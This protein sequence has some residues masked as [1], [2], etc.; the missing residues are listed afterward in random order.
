[1]YSKHPNHTYGRNRNNSANNW[2]YMYNVHEPGSYFFS[3]HFQSL[4]TPF[5][6]SY[7]EMAC[8]KLCWWKESRKLFGRRQR[9]SLLK[10]WWSGGPLLFPLFLSTIHT[11]VKYCEKGVLYIKSVHFKETVAQSSFL[12]KAL[13]FSLKSKQ[14]HQKWQHLWNK[15]GLYNCLLKMNGL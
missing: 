5:S 4:D 12:S 10:W 8:Q 1:M 2:A 15:W 3:P 9:K 11:V 13:S 7:L 6:A 14:S